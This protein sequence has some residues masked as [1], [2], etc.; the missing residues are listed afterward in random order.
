MGT[1]GKKKPTIMQ[2]FLIV[3]LALV[4]AVVALPTNEVEDGSKDADAL[5]I[6]TYK[7]C[8]HHHH[9]GTWC[10]HHHRICDT[11]NLPE[12]AAAV[13]LTSEDGSKD[14]TGVIELNS[15]QPFEA[16]DADAWHHHHHHHHYHHDKVEDTNEIEDGSKDAWHHHHHDK[17]EDADAWHHHHH[18]K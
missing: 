4:A 12:G 18:D 17:V 6:C 10:H 5:H 7:Y 11:E 9:L 2:K 3:A 16:Q 14:A 8:I 15:E 1:V 13:L